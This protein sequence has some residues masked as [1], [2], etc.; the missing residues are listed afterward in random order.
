MYTSIQGIF[1]RVFCDTPDMDMCASDISEE[2][3]SYIEKNEEE[4]FYK[5]YYTNL[6]SDQK[7]SITLDE[8]ITGLNKYEYDL[9]DYVTG[10]KDKLLVLTGEKGWG[11]S[12]LIKYVFF[13]LL[14]RHN[15]NILPI[16]ISFNKLIAEFDYKDYDR[17][18]VPFYKCLLDRIRHYTK[19][20]LSDYQSDFWQYIK[21]FPVHSD[22]ATQCELLDQ[23]E[24]SNVITSNKKLDRFSTL[25]SKELLLNETIFDS[26]RYFAEKKGIKPII[27]F[28]DLDPLS[29]DFLKYLFSES[30]GC[31]KQVFNQQF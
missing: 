15:T 19:G 11:K 31:K 1:H 29:Y 6:F 10:F 24:L 22:F 5:Q 25:V 21:K 4:R 16:Y 18:K 27:I 9:I 28:D 7:Y 3:F 12:T 2:G 14:S 20:Y 30:Y 17:F 23:L 26:L 8:P 13:H